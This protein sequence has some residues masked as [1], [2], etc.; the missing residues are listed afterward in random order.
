MVGREDVRASVRLANDGGFDGQFMY[1]PHLRS[2][3]ALGTAE[4]HRCLAP[5]W[6][7]V[8]YRFG[9]IGYPWLV[10]LLALGQWTAVPGVM[11]WLLVVATAIGGFAL[12]SA[13]QDAVLSPMIGLGALFVPGYWQSIQNGLPEPIAGMLRWYLADA[14][15]RAVTAAAVCCALALARARNLR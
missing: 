4:P 13:A 9:R 15:A 1:F 12:A 10:T 11:W 2:A 6:T 5:W 7:Q 3:D 8:P 14:A